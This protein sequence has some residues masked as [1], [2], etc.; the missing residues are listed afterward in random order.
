MN[1]NVKTLVIIRGLR[2]VL[3]MLL[4]G[5]CFFVLAL[6]SQV[7]VIE[8]DV[9]SSEKEVELK[10][11]NPYLKTSFFELYDLSKTEFILNNPTY[12]QGNDRFLWITIAYDSLYSAGSS[13]ATTFSKFEGGYFADF[14]GFGP[15]NL[16]SNKISFYTK[17][18]VA[19]N[20]QMV[21]NFFLTE[22]ILFLLAMLGREVYKLFS[23]IYSDKRYLNQ[24]VFGV[25]TAK[26]HMFAYLFLSLMMSGLLYLS[27]RVPLNNVSSDYYVQKSS[28]LFS[29]YDISCAYQHIQI[30]AAD[31]KGND[32]EW[33][34]AEIVEFV[35]NN[36][37]PSKTEIGPK[38]VL[39][40]DVPMD[41]DVDVTFYVRY[42]QSSN[43]QEIRLFVLTTLLL[44]FLE[45]SFFYFRKWMRNRA[46]AIKSTNKKK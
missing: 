17:N 28:S 22:I 19:E 7:P 16:V 41:E 9:S 46:F 2:T 45:R 4:L 39:L 38:S 20:T 23:D 18:L 27:N 29:L 5:L 34:S 11:P 25:K 14:S 36:V 3:F 40:K 26:W 15:V 43:Y 33:R 21:R 30:P 6:T 37:C 24:R 8:K 12:E 42:L 13:I 31:R 32:V 10:V 1:T 44:F 35:P